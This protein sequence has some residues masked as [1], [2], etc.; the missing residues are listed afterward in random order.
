MIIAFHYQD[1]GCFLLFIFFSIH[2]VQSKMKTF[3]PHL[4]VF[5]IFICRSL[6]TQV[7][8]EKKKIF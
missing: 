5:P 8:K 7:R 1:S 2:V 3:F 4:I 6:F